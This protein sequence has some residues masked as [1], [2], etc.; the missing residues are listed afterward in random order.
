M[1]DENLLAFRDEWSRIT[2]SCSGC[3]GSHARAKCT[4][5]EFL[6]DLKALGWVRLNKD[7]LYPELN[8]MYFY[9]KDC[10]NAEFWTPA[11]TA[12]IIPLYG[13]AT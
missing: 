2:F 1:K 12:A 6:A 10:Q 9:C 5:D 8:R 4:M 7:D 11:H 13:T 3:G